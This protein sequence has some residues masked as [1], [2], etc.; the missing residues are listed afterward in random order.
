MRVTVPVAGVHEVPGRRSPAWLAMVLAALAIASACSDDETPGGTTSPSPTVRSVTLVASP[1]TLPVQGGDV[2]I[3]ATVTS[4]SGTNMAGQQV[5]FST[6]KGT[7]APNAPVTTDGNG[8]ARVKLT[9]TETAVVRASTGGVNSSDLNLGVREAA[10]LTVTLDPP[11]PVAT[12]PLKITVAAKRG[13]AD[14][15]GALFL[16]YGNGE[17]LE[18]GTINGTRTIE[19]TYKAQG[20]F[21]LTVAVQEGD[22][23]S[24]RETTRINVKEAPRGGG[25]GGNGRDDIDARAV[26]WFADC[27]I[28]DWP[29]E[30]RVLDVSI[31]SN[32]IC[33]DYTGRGTKGT[34]DIGIPVDATLWVFAEFNGV[35]YGA[36]WDH[37]RPGTF[38]KAEGAHS[39]GSEQI[40]IPPMDASWVPR[41]GDRVGFMVSGGYVRRACEPQTVWRTNIALITWP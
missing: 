21:N 14:V 31:S 10:T 35:W 7:L 25:G 6:T 11:E 36:T 28:S 33:V 40:R 23:S 5:T 34:F 32:E 3:T 24:T 18:A 2:D 38:C 8:Q 15:T 41:R 17:G 20:G 12:Q 9:T 27:N 22:G 29:I 13:G 4:S 19:Y 30:E 26:R 37:L 16:N 39:L 1:S